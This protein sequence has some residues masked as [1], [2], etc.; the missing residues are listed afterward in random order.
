[1]IIPAIWHERERQSLFLFYFFIL[2]PWQ[3]VP[4]TPCLFF[5]HPVT[6]FHKVRSKAPAG[7]WI[8]SSY[9]RFRN[10]V[11]RGGMAALGLIK[12]FPTDRQRCIDHIDRI[13][14]ADSIECRL[15]H[16]TSLKVKTPHWHWLRPGD[17]HWKNSKR[18]LETKLKL[19]MLPAYSSVRRPYHNHVISYHII[20]YGIVSYR[21]VAYPW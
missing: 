5:C 11:T 3:T 8:I 14:L 18:E 13:R 15:F 17:R 4:P 9:W 6:F 10:D 1:M 19:N 16:W 7:A 2:G 20:S 12:L 21:I